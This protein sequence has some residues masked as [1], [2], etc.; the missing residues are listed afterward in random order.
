MFWIRT[1]TPDTFSHI[2]VVKLIV[3]KG[4]IMGMAYILSNTLSSSPIMNT[5]VNIR[6][7]LVEWF[8]RR[9]S[10]YLQIRRFKSRP[11]I[12]LK[13]PMLKNFIFRL[14]KS[15]SKIQDYDVTH[16]KNDENVIGVESLTTKTSFSVT[17]QPSSSQ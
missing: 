16:D 15:Y 7:S 12:F 11:R 13:T 1:P 4:R 5:D 10:K 14:F 9:C 6:Q 3:W 2:F 8:I 17:P